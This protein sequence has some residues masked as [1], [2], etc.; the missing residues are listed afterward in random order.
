M[1]WSFWPHG[2]VTSRSHWDGSQLSREAAGMRISTSKSEAMVLSRK[3]VDC[4]LRR[5][6][7]LLHVERIQLRWLARMP[8][9]RL[10]A[11]VFGR[12]VHPGRDP[13]A[14]QGHAG[15]IFLDCL[16]NASGSPWRSWLKWTGERTVWASLL[17]LLPPLPGPRYA[18]GRWTDRH[19]RVTPCWM[20]METLT[21]MTRWTWP[22]MWRNCSAGPWPTNGAV[23]SPEP[24]T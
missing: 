2:V 13:R 18:V 17:G 1:M 23:N 21:W 24:E 12:H 5:A 9:G 10:P 14:D 11:E 16:G 22:A 8:P 15:G 6:A 7:T 19:T 20:Q 3:R 4:P